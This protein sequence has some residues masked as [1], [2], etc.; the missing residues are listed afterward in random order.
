[1]TKKST[2]ETI[3]YHCMDEQGFLA[4]LK[5]KRVFDKNAYHV[6]LTA[7]QDYK[8][9]IS[10]SATVNRKVAGCTHFL[11]YTLLLE[12]DTFPQN[13]IENELVQDAHAETWELVQEILGLQ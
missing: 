5:V 11:V 7:L 1:M 4:K 9:E 2:E 12:L 8:R 10:D 13:A 6:L 3:V